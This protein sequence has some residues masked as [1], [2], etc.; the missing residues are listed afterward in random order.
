MG[1]MYIFPVS[2]DASEGDR[3][4]VQDETLTLRT[5]GLPMIFWGYLGAAL[6]VL[7]IMW[8]ASRAVVLKLLS[9]TEDPTLLFLGHLVQWTLI[10]APIVLFGFFFYEKVIS[11]K[12]ATLVVS[13]RIFFI[14]FWKK[15]YTLSS[16][17]SII[18]NHF[19][20]SPNMAKIRN[21]QGLGNVEAMKHFE[22]K[23]YFE[24]SIKTDKDKQVSI[25]RHSRK[26]DLVKLRELL[27]KY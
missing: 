1:L 11:K 17:D 27:L 2:E 16:K 8:L 20:D 18:V 19:M 15:T 4:E 22:N 6:S 12:G 21:R 7:L 25:D 13:H 23:G 14:T 26:A 5:Y 24:L 10:F 3:A 9:Y